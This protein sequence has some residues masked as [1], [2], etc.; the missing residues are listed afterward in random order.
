MV[1]T[2]LETLPLVSQLRAGG[3]TDEQA[4]T[5]TSVLRKTQDTRLSHLA[6]KDSTHCV[7]AAMKA[8]FARLKA[9]IFTAMFWQTVVIVGAIGN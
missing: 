8:D 4:E 1:I 9:D 5:L 3:F 2:A 6:A 7:I